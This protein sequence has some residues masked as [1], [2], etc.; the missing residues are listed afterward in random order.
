MIRHALIVADIEGSSGCFSYDASAFMTAAWARA[1]LEM[2]RDVNAV[3][4]ALFDAGVETIRVKDFHRTG[5]NLLPEE[6]DRRAAVLHGYRNGPVPGFGDPGNATAA[7]FLGMHAASGGPGFLPHTLT[8]RISEIRINGRLVPEI[9]LFSGSLAAFGVRPAF[10]SGCP[11]ACRQAEAVIPGIVTQ[12][13]DKSS[14]RSPQ[15]TDRWRRTLAASAVR[16]AGETPAQPPFRG[17]PLHAR[18]GFRD[19]PEVAR[20][21]GK[22]WGFPVHR[23]MVRITASDLNALYMNLIRLAYLTPVA[24]KLIPPGLWLSNIR[25]DLGIRWARRKIR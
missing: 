12:S 16:A 20:W 3:V 10:F 18:V 4:T 9:L 24:E 2:S 7:F 21:V 17:G 14:P 6:I 8:S 23:G 11:V 1:C 5:Y 13:I 25:G 15:K 22:R 19:G